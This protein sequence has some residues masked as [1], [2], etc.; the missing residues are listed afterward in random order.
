MCRWNTIVGSDGAIWA[1]PDPAKK[2]LVLFPYRLSSSNPL[3]AYEHT[4]ALYVRAITVQ[5]FLAV[6][7]AVIDLRR[8]NQA[9]SKAG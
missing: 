7:A 5:R 9:K 6:I 4:C 1:A 8:S 3:A 2:F